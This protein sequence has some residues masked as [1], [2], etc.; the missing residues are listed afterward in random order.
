MVNLFTE[1]RKSQ[2]SL[3]IQKWCA[4]APPGHFRFIGAGDLEKLGFKASTL[5]LDFSSRKD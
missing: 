4:R 3:S 5:H 1:P 2:R